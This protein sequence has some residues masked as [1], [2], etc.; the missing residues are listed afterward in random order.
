MDWSLCV[1]LLRSFRQ[2][3]AHAIFNNL[4][5]AGQA[6][7]TMYGKMIKE[8]TLVQLPDVAFALFDDA[9][10]TGLRPDYSMLC[11]LATA[12]ALFTDSL[13]SSACIQKVITCLA[14]WRIPAGIRFFICIL[15]GYDLSHQNVLFDSLAR[16]L[17][18]RLQY[19]NNELNYVLMVNAARR[20]DLELAH[21]LA[22]Q[23]M[24]SLSKFPRNEV[25]LRKIYQPEKRRELL[26][27]E[28]FPENNFTANMKLSLEIDASSRSL[29]PKSLLHSA[30]DMVDKGYTPSFS[31]FSQLIRHIALCN[32][33]NMAIEAF[34]R[35]SDAG[36]PYNVEIL[37]FVLG[38]HLRSSSRARSV[39]IFEDIRSR[40]ALSDAGKI[41]LP[42]LTMQ[43]YMEFLIER[44][45]LVAAH[46]MLDFLRTL[47]CDYNRLPYSP[48]IRYYI[49]RGMLDDAH[50]L[51]TSVV[52]HD[53]PIDSVVIKMYCQVLLENAETADCGNFLRYIHRTDRIASVP[54]S[55]FEIF[56]L[57]CVKKRRIADIEWVVEVLVN[58]P[59]ETT[60]VW[61]AILKRL[62]KSSNIQDVANI[63]KMA[64]DLA[65]DKGRAGMH[66][67][68]AAVDVP[69]ALVVADNVLNVLGKR[70]GDR[71]THLYS[72]A[73][74]IFAR[75]W[76]RYHTLAKADGRH[77]HESK[78]SLVLVLERHIYEAAALGI[79]RELLGITL[80]ALAS[81]SRNM[82]LQEYIKILESV[83][84]R[85]YS[86]GLLE[87]ICV[88]F[89]R[90]GRTRDVDV[91]LELMWNQTIMLDISV[92]NNLM[93]SINCMPIPRGL[94]MLN[95][96]GINIGRADIKAAEFNQTA[97]VEDGDNE[98]IYNRG[99][100]EE[101]NREEDVLLPG[102]VDSIE[103]PAEDVN[104]LYLTFYKENLARILSIWRRFEFYSTSPDIASYSILLGAYTKAKEYQ[105]GEDL[106]STVISMFG[107][108]LHIS[109]QWITLRLKRGNVKGALHIFDAL[110]NSDKCNELS[111]IDKRYMGLHYIERSA[112]HF[113]PFV[114]YYL[115]L[116]KHTLATRFLLAMHTLGFKGTTRM[117]CYILMHAAAL[118]NRQ[119]VV[120]IVHQMVEFD[121]PI[122]A[123]LTEIIRSY[124]ELLKHKNTTSGSLY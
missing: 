12:S 49:A 74:S 8:Y 45:D 111:R 52:Q 2:K 107:H 38:L 93:S 33:Q 43:K 73:F 103:Q 110:G 116:G 97:M 21:I 95:K 19:T 92:L 101:K 30:L 84:N 3:E 23:V 28:R 53:I 18:H 47:P 41:S 100:R 34:D 89:A 70:L 124:S 40:L 113:F 104:D 13:K 25:V 50:K 120:D 87:S 22:P 90:R 82:D 39:D 67:L 56:V 46:Q 58:S 10:R 102:I 29:K 115:G 32:N 88:G 69:L 106:V 37:L 81:N 15:K 76:V 11:E 83:P 24:E 31:M 20:G 94:F 35:L 105:Q 61:R 77:F 59:G 62:G 60:G 99:L 114:K 98:R 63:V 26:N 85:N 51:I 55:V 71:S 44:D 1:A 16:K 75:L 17:V 80:R 112:F 27:L 96:S 7:S 72:A 78:E 119:L 54:Y 121:V 4:V 122:N 36:V 64:I 9:C 79:N 123:Q 48:L 117:Y 68:S 14:N 109:C 118:N 66:L 91:I 5:A 86:V 65:T 108:E 6:N 42:G 57:H